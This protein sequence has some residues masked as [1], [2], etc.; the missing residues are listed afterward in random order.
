MVECCAQAI[1]VGRGGQLLQAG[2]Q[3]GAGYLVGVD[4][5]SCD[6]EHLKQRPP[7]YVC[8]E[9]TRQ[10]G[11]IESWHCRL[12]AADQTL[13]AEGEIRVTGAL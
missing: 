4:G 3:S 8:A 11:A 10:V 13:V 1:A 9:K 12:M 5:F 6:I 7:F 2:F